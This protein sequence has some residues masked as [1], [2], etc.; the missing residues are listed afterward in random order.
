MGGVSGLEHAFAL[1]LNVSSLAEV[2]ARRRVEPQAGM[3]VLAVVPVEEVLA[4][5]TRVFDGAE[6][7]GKLR[8]IL[9]RLEVRLRIRVVVGAVRSG[10]ALG[11]PEVSQQQRH[12]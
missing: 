10:V 3:A 12:R 8:S 5:G 7:P 2:D 1:D 11:H 9:E 4:E 6:T